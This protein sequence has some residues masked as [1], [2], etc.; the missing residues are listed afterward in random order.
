MVNA[1]VLLVVDTSRSSSLQPHEFLSTEARRVSDHDNL[2]FLPKPYEIATLLPLLANASANHPP[3]RQ[4][5]PIGVT[6][7]K[8]FNSL[9]RTK[10]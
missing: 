5:P 1:A 2:I 8:N 7:P 9:F 10:A 6:G 3:I 4:T